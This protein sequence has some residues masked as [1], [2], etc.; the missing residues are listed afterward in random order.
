MVGFRFLMDD[1][2]GD[3]SAWLLTRLSTD[4]ERGR[5]GEERGKERERERE[6]GRRCHVISRLLTNRM[7]K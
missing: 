7:H 3:L 2:D 4:G 1:D 5:E 6:R